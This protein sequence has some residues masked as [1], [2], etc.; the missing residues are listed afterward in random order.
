MPKK[1]W[2]PQV[3]TEFAL[4]KNHERL[5]YPFGVETNAEV[6]ENSIQSIGSWSIDGVYC[7]DAFEVD[8]L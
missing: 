2:S 4:S 1:L 8:L 5:V 7:T 3:K 6:F